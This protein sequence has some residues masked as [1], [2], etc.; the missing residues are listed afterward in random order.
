MRLFLTMAGLG[1]AFLPL[2]AGTQPKAPR[3]R[4]NIVLAMADDQ[5]WGDMAYQ[6][7]AVLKTPTFDEM[8]RSGLRLDRF[9]A[10]APVCSPTRAAVLTGRTPN[11]MGCFQWGYHLRPGE[12]TLAERLRSAGYRTGHF[13]KWHLGSMRADSETSPGGRGF[14]TYF[15]SPNF[16]EI[17]P[18]L[19]RDGRAEKVAGEGSEVIVD[20]A[21]D[22]IRRSRDSG[23][24]C[25][26]VVWFGSPHAPH[27]ATEADRALYTGQPPARANFLAEVTAMDRAMG[28]LRTGLRSLGI[29]DTTLLWYHSDNGAIPQGSTGG[30]RG[31]KGSV[32]EG[33]L[34]V[35]GLV[36]WPAVIRRPRRSAFPCGAVDV[37]P[38]VLSAAGVDLPA[39]PLDGQSLLP[40]F[41]GKETPRKPLGFWDYPI[42]G[43]AVRSA[44]LL[45]TL[46]REQAAGAVRPAAEADP[47]PAAQARRDYPEDRFPGHAAW[48]DGTLKLHRIEDRQGAVRWELYD[49]AADP[50]EAKELGPENG[51]G[52]RLRRELERWLAGAARSLNGKDYGES[53]RE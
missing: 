23:E 21:L 5:G 49:L 44:E 25:L 29:A 34:R 12:I 3:Q 36:E 10:A 39:R 38:T 18:W 17:D 24:A 26:A 33:G 32:W 28:K 19:C 45:E 37:F 47:L 27:V 22:F 2:S 11:R 35:P 46:A 30:L 7:D 1:L 14:Q 31:R 4:P 43:I 9:Y 15:S 20:A 41:E 53:R 16:F 40:L 42:P 13:G 48:I 8:A 6:G 51:E 52:S 50:G